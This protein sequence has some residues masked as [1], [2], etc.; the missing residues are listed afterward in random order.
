MGL[1][2]HASQ[3]S[4]K[5]AFSASESSHVVITSA[6]EQDSTVMHVRLGGRDE[7]AFKKAERG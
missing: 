5:C 6:D 7:M 2:K 3:H 4:L 1:L